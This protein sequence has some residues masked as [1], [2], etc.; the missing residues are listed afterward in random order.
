M[1]ADYTVIVTYLKNRYDTDRSPEK[2]SLAYAIEQ[3][4]DPEQLFTSPIPLPPRAMLAALF[5][6]WRLR[7]THY[8]LVLS[9]SCMGGGYMRIVYCTS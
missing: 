3:K 6:V 5:H 8:H 4:L 1:G 2:I 7:I 9:F